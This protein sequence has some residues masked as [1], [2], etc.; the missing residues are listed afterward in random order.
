MS[1]NVVAIDGPSG[2]GKSTVAQG[3]ATQLGFRL[4]DTGA[5][6][7]AAAVGAM[8]A[9]IELSHASSVEQLVQ[10]Y[11]IDFDESGTR[12][13]LNGVEV[14]DQIRTLEVGQA[15]STISQ[16]LGVREHLVRL[17]QAVISSGGF[18]LEGRDVTTV[19]APHARLKIFLTASIEERARRR[20]KELQAKGD[21]VRLQEVV[22]DVVMRDHRDYTRQES[23]LQLAEDAVIV[24]TFAMTPDQVIH[25]VV[26]LY[27]SS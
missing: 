14:A 15:A 23:P 19:V 21:P 9:Q 11:A 13:R 17:Q 20:W 24:E 12:V 8:Q 25:H 18:V 4:L 5:M 26:E 7:R 22:K 10:S 1:L 16:Y 3:A 6:Y 27:R 2:A